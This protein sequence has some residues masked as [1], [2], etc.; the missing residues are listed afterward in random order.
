[1]SEKQLENDGKGKER[2]IMKVGFKYAP[3]QTGGK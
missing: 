3:H 2:V 1:M